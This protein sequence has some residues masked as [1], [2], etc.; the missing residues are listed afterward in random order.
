MTAKGHV[1]L[2]D[3]DHDI[4]LSM[5]DVLRHLGYGVSDFA[6]AA[7]F[8]QQAQRYSPAV[9]VLDMR[10]P[11]MT[12]LDLQKA[13][14]EKDWSMPIIY[15]SGDSQS[16]EI[17][18]A[19]KFGAIDFLWKPIAHTQLVQAI[20]KGLKLD[21]QRHADQQR[22]K[23]VASF[24]QSLSSK[25]QDM[26]AMM[27]LGHGNKVIATAKNV[28]ADTVKKHRAQILEKMQVRSL[29]ELLALCKDF[30]PAHRKDQKEN[31]I[32]N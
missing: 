23:R 32:Q 6:S 5:A 29:A 21:V 9:L 22:L 4:R 11:H 31:Q 28:M 7:S 13:L 2:V 3:D 17:I 26:F 24:Y 27:L 19:M 15:M 20:D 25:E 30:V 18:D 16:Q 14:L 12:G 8:L 10:M 1:F